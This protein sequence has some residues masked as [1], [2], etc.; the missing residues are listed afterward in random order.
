MCDPP[1][2]NEDSLTPDEK[3]LI[4]DHSDIPILSKIK[5]MDKKDL[6]KYN[7]YLIIDFKHFMK[8]QMEWLLTEKWLLGDRVKHDPSD[9]E[10]MN[11]PYLHENAVRYRVFYVLKYPERVK[12]K[13]E[14]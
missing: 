8:L 6:E 13:T 12:S 10:L 7:C 3:K 2:S 11:D 9:E 5:K 14:T 1:Y 4:S